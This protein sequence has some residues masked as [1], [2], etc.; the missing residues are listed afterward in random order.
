MVLDMKN[1]NGFTLIELLCVIAILAVVTTIAS[2]SIINL[3]NS[4]KE[5]LYCAKL[6]MIESAAKEYAISH[7]AEIN[8]STTYY[9]GSK[10]LII[11]VQD[12]IV[13]GNFAPDKD[14]MVLSPLNNES[15]NQL[16]II[17]YYKNNQLYAYINDNKVC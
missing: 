10:S 9:E 7:E 5:N 14:D 2:A 15:L 17:L 12:L 13:N 11:T 16:Q 1:K 6:K 8:N 4:S 3:S